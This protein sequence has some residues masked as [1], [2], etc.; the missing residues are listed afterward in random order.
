LPSACY[1]RSGC[2]LDLNFVYVAQAQLQD[3]AD[4]GA[5]GGARLL[6]CPDGTLNH[7]TGICLDEDGNQL[8]D[9]EGNPLPSAIAG[10]RAAAQA[11]HTLGSAVQEVSVQGGHGEFH[12]SFPDSNGIERGGEFTGANL[13]TVEQTPLIDPGTGQFRPLFPDG[14]GI[15]DLNG[16]TCID[17]DGPCDINAVRVTTATETTVVVRKLR[18][19]R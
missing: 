6:Y 4:A 9:V 11:N 18:L 15:S 1:W 16:D 8:L 19:S 13:A 5:L 12:S 14:S 3:A 7:T 2:W 10:A 17:L